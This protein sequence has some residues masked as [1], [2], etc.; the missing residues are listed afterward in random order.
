M[1]VHVVDVVVFHKA[2]LLIHLVV[3]DVVLLLVHAVDVAL[4]DV[5]FMLSFWDTLFF[6]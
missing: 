4:L 3:V 6:C 2:L 5:V 1:R